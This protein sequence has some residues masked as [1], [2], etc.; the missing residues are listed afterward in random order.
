[1]DLSKARKAGASAGGAGAAGPELH[2]LAAVMAH[3]DMCSQKEAVE[4]IKAGQ[5]TID[6]EAPLFQNKR[7]PATATVELTAKGRRRQRVKLCLVQHKPFSFVS[8]VQK[9]SKPTR[10]R[11]AKSLLEWSNAADRAMAKSAKKMKRANPSQNRGLAV[12]GRLDTDSSGL[13]IWTENGALSKLITSS[14]VEKEYVV[15]LAAKPDVSRPVDL[16]EVCRRFRRFNL[17]GQLLL[18]VKAEQIDGEGTVALRMVLREGKY[19]QIRRMCDA[20]GWQVVKLRRVRIGNLSLANT[21]LKS[22]QWAPFSPRD[23]D[24]GFPDWSDPPPSGRA[25][26]A[27]W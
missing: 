11:Q 15:D 1:M 24:P 9:G 5:V 10:S 19:R 4:Y 20:M 27:V 17:D 25:G 18:P 6:G 7:I 26:G 16:K 8:E 21:V 12:A 22:G 14:R 2:R 3:R 13:M 23:I